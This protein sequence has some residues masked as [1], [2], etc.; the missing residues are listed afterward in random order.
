MML[1]SCQDWGL[2]GQPVM[3]QMQEAEL[4]EQ[5][6]EEKSQCPYITWPVI[7]K[8]SQWHWHHCAH[9]HFSPPLG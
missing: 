1:G 6:K 9:D 8:I 5:E 3:L 4:W 7:L 2:D